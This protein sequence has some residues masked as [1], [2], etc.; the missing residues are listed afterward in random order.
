MTFIDE[1]FWYAIDEDFWYVCELAMVS[2]LETEK[3]PLS[4]TSMSKLAWIDIF[5]STLDQ[6]LAIQ[7]HGE[8]SIDK[9]RIL[10]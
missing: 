3:E 10:F 8:D 9:Q 4:K 5:N 7:A 6:K 1:D 2:K